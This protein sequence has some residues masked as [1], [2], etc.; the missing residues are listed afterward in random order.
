MYY[1]SQWCVFM[2]FLCAKV[3]GSMSLCFLCIFLGSFSPGN[4][5]A[6]SCSSVFLSLL[7]IVV[8]ILDIL[9]VFWRE[10]ERNKGV[11]WVGRSQE[12]SGSSWKRE[13]SS[14][15]IIWRNLFSIFKKKFSFVLV[16]QSNLGSQEDGSV[17]KALEFRSPEPTE[18]PGR[19][20]CWPVNPVTGR[21][22]QGISGEPD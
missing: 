6:W 13:P 8:I 11:V 1:C 18:A 4:F 20:G 5:F 15:Y 2:E 22:R 21:Q 14:E 12:E 19:W 7:F 17:D 3:Y 16:G 10:R 9:F